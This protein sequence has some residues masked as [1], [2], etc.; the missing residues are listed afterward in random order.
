MT[1]FEPR[2]PLDYEPATFPEPDPTYSPVRRPPTARELL[3]RIWAPVLALVGAAVKFGFVFLKFFGIFVSVAAYSLIWGWRFAIGFVLLIL[4]HELGHYAEAKRQ[5]LDVGLPVFVPFM[6]AFVALR[7]VPFDPWRN[8]LVSIAGPIAG[9]LGSAAALVAGH[10]TGSGLLLAL[11]YSGFLLNLIN[12][13]PVGFLDGGHIWQS[14]AVLRRGGGRRR[15]EDARRLG[16]VAGAIYVATA[17][18]LVAGM[19]DAHVPQ[20]RL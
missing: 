10:A 16:W 5:G 1:A 13:A 7:N 20:H 18:A 2:D 19:V 17:A 4:V 8:V 3:A 11:A 9:A 6:G 15:P 12:L 14:L